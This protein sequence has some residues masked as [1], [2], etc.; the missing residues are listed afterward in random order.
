MDRGFESIH[1]T[2]KALDSRLDRLERR[3]DEL[4]VPVPAPGDPDDNDEEDVLFERID[5]K[6][7]EEIGDAKN[8]L[9]LEI[10][11]QI[12]DAKRQLKGKVQEWVGG[13]SLVCEFSSQSSA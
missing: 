1:G 9:F 5:E 3:L 6:I 4:E 2:L 10:G 12:K 13:A 11:D 7:K 8:G